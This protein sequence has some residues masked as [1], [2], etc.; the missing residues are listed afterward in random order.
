[1]RQFLLLRIHDLEILGRAVV[2]AGL[3]RKLYE[4]SG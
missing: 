3:I 2:A 1:M 4:L